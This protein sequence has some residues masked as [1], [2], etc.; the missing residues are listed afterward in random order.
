MTTTTVSQVRDGLKTTITDNISSIRVY[1]TVPE[2]AN[3]PAIV[4]EPASATFKGFNSLCSMWEYDLFVLVSRVDAPRGQ[5]LLDQYIDGTGASSIRQVIHN[6]PTLGLPGVDASVETMRGYAGTFEST[7]V[8][9]IG[10][11]L[12]VAVLITV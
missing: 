10:A 4:V 6:N 11:I 5:D 9:Y 8:K 12:R 2:V 1:D 3:V 7:G